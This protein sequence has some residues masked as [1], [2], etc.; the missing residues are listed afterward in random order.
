M[1]L[2]KPDAS[3]RISHVGQLPLASFPAGKYVMR[4]TVS[5][6]AQ[7]EARDAAFAVVD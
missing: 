5:Q 4:V 7:K 2:A 6:G 1:E 3:G